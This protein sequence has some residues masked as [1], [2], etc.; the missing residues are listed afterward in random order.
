MRFSLL[1]P[2]VSEQFDAGKSRNPLGMSKVLLIGWDAADWKVISPL[3][4]QG[5]MPALQ[6]M[7]EQGSSGN[8][9][10]L[11][12]VLSPTLWTS[13]ATGKR[14]FNH[15]IL[16]FSEPTPDGK[17]VR[18]ITN[19]QR[20]TK[21][22][23][24]ILNQEGYRSNVVGWWPSHPAEPINGAMVSNHYLRAPGT[25][26]K[27]WPIQKGTV[28]PKHLEEPM[29][30]LRFHPAE[31]SADMVLPFIPK[32]AEIDQ[33]KD[34]R[35]QS[36]LK[37]LADCTTIHASATWL[38]Q[39]EPADFTAVYYDAI[40]HFSHGFMKF[41]PPR[42][43]G[44]SEEDFALF[45]GVI[46]GAY[47]YHD[48]MLDT[49][50]QL[51][52]EDTTVILMSDHGFHPDHLRPQWIPKDPAGPAI[53][54]REHGIFVIK[55]PGIRQ[56][57]TITGANV[58]DVM[59]TILTSFGLPLG[60]DLDGTPLLSVF[61]SPSTI[62]TIPSWDLVEGEAGLHP[63]GTELDSDEQEQ[64]LRQLEDLGYIEKADPTDEI[65]VLKTQ[66]E[67]D[68]NL[69]CSYI[70][71]DRHGDAM[72]ILAT[73]YRDHPGE[74]RIGL[75]LALCYQ[76]L[77]HLKALRI[78]IEGINLRRQ[79]DAE[80]AR[81]ALKQVAKL[82]EEEKK[83]ITSSQAKEIRNLQAL[84]R[85]NR[86]GINSLM[87]HLLL[88]EGKPAKALELL[89]E[90][91]ERTP[92][93]VSF[94]L[95]RGRAFL[96]LGQAHRA[97]E[98]F[99]KARAIDPHRQ[100]LYLGIASANLQLKHF[101]AA[102]SAAAQAISLN[103]R[104]AVAHF[105]YGQAL[106][107][108]GQFDE[109]IEA[110]E[111]ALRHNPVFPQAHQRLRFIAQH[112][113]HHPGR[114]A[115]YAQQLQELR[116]HRS[117]KPK[118]IPVPPPRG[119][120]IVEAILEKRH[121]EKA[122]AWSY[123]GKP[124]TIVTGLPRSGTSMLMQML[125]AGGMSITSDEHRTPDEDNPAGYLEDE[126]VKRLHQHNTWI[127]GEGGK[128]IKVV[129]PLI[130]YLPVGPD[131]RILFLNRDLDEILAS[132][133]KMLARSDK[134]GADL[135]TS[136]LREIYQQ[137]LDG[138]R[139]LL[140]QSDYPVLSLNYHE[141][142]ATPVDHAEKITSFFGETLELTAMTKAVRSDLYRNRQAK[143]GVFFPSITFS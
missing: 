38:M 1:A 43:E 77:G 121:T 138:L 27:D 49:L 64:A 88:A 45:Q 114:A 89:D 67:L 102:Q 79:N 18:P 7:M 126:R 120:G 108:T 15:G 56:K 130:P 73:L 58:I 137:Q 113:Q 90:L 14:P 140:E 42:R 112:I 28:H 69:A 20:S 92:Q 119:G 44:I 100:H 86:R 13:I 136:K 109:A 39:N 82:N 36:F 51:A 25:D 61:E 62:S 76:A 103:D 133:K 53:E 115:H 129:A 98:T 46:E 142:V 71:A 10:T 87:A 21:A 111:T 70:H 11:Y 23:W 17:A 117:E 78:L 66:L 32:A 24:N 68:Y 81:H 55:G 34:R 41:H 85:I 91:T 125:K 47:R 54:H 63:P 143:K 141:V 127:K 60:D 104:S 94:L 122:I 9:S 3:I 131:Y 84:A 6:R 116:N 52:G 106:F 118:D 110:Y 123:N 30:D 132:Q 135:E 31:I 105:L 50:L 134:K 5:K 48:M 74:Y 83:R 139:K 33:K 57:H 75:R 99:E 59:P 40:D 72:P 95:Q 128:V 97:L 12:P 93:A 37:I 19:L 107:R 35:L 96:K 22:I 80:D 4:E 8:L 26:P 2:P 16:G 124:I 29:R 101:E 65:N